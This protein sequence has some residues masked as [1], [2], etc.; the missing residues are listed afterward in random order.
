MSKN[1]PY[2]DKKIYHMGVLL[3]PAGVSAL[4]FNSPRPINLKLAL[5]TLRNEAVTCP[6]CKRI[7]AASAYI[8]QTHCIGSNVP[9]AEINC[10]YCLHDNCAICNESGCEHSVLDRHPKET[11]H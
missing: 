1:D 5:W 11:I 4:C 2:H 6:K 10:L 8:A 7:L 9:L 3:S